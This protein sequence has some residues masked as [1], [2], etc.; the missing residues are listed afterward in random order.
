MTNSYNKKIGNLIVLAIM[1]LTL[2]IPFQSRCE[3]DLEKII[4]EYFEN[5]SS[6]KTHQNFYEQEPIAADALYVEINQQIEESDNAIAGF[7]VGAGKYCYAAGKELLNMIEDLAIEGSHFSQYHKEKSACFQEMDETVSD[8]DN[9]VEVAG[10]FYGEFV[11]EF[12]VIGPLRGIKDGVKGMKNAENGEEFG[13]AFSQTVASAAAIYAIGKGSVNLMKGSGSLGVASAGSKASPFLNRINKI[14]KSPKLIAKGNAILDRLAEIG[15]SEKFTFIQSLTVEEAYFF[16]NKLKLN[17]ANLGKLRSRFAQAEEYYISSQ[18]GKPIEIHWDNSML[19]PH[20]GLKVGKTVIHG[21]PGYAFTVWSLE[22]SAARFVQQ[23][24]YGVKRYA[25][26]L[27]NTEI[28]NL[29]SWIAAN[30]GKTFWLGCSE[31]ACKALRQGAGYSVAGYWVEK[32]ASFHPGVLDTILNT[33]SKHAGKTGGRI[34]FLQFIGMSK[35][36]CPIFHAYVNWLSVDYAISGFFIALNGNEWTVGD[37][38]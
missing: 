17:K 8:A 13:Q 24:V 27:T 4:K 11:P 10:K 28:A 22:Q 5:I 30:S 1:S 38:Q 19:L 26:N 20:V 32:L 21:S 29:S 18:K 23:S 14:R 9:V 33:V 31:L 25:V 15:F 12:V 34:E 6:S 35:N 16:F 2:L 7:F 3:D 36:N 37:D